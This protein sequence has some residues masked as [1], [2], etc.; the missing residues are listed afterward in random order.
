VDREGCRRN[1][2]IEKPHAAQAAD[3]FHDKRAL[4]SPALALSADEIS[5]GK[6]GIGQFFGKFA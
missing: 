5:G 3:A 2:G 6:S 1:F 4:S